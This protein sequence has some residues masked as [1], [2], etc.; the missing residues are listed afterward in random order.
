MVLD[1]LEIINNSD[2]FMVFAEC[3]GIGV[4]I[5]FMAYSLGFIFNA[6]IQLL[7]RSL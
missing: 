4:L 5:G 6:M 1:G 7:R 3:M 2:A